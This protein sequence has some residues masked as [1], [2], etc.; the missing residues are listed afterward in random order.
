MVLHSLSDFI[1]M[2]LLQYD[3]QVTVLAC[4]TWAYLNWDTLD[5]KKSPENITRKFKG[6]LYTITSDQ[7][8]VRQAKLKTNKQKAYKGI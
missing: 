6:N 3:N 8:T 2:T 4:L 1:W 5:M 7:H